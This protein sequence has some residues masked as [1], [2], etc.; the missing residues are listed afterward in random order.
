MSED[1]HE[2][3][4]LDA[5]ADYKAKGRLGFS[6]PGHKQARGA[7]PSV[8]D[9]LGDAVFLGDMLAFGGLDGR[10]RTSGVLRRAQEL[11][12]DAVHAEHTFFSTCGSSL[13]VKAARDERS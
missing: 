11:M 6:P 7:A 8:R 10:R 4:V 3:P 1:H 5:L 12:A 2:A 9:V 13:S